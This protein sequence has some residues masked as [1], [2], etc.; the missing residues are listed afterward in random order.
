MTDAPRSRLARAPAPTAADHPGHIPNDP[1]PEKPAIVARLEEKHK[2]L[3]DVLGTFELDE[4]A[5]PAATE[6]KSDEDAAKVTRFATAARA[7][8][9]EAE[10]VRT[11]EKADFLKAGQAIDGLFNKGLKEPL[12]ALAEA[13]EKRLA[14]YLAAKAEA[15][16]ARRREEQERLRIAQ[17][18]AQQ[19][20]TEARAAAQAREA[21]AAAA[22]E[23]VRRAS[24]DAE[25]ETA[26]LAMQEAEAA[27]IVEQAA[28]DQAAT[29]TAKTERLVGQHE[30]VLAKG[31]GR[32]SA[33]KVGGAGEGSA[34]LEEK[35]VH[36]IVDAAAL[37]ASLG[38][39]AP[40]LP[41]YVLTEALARVAKEHE[42]RLSI[43]GVKFSKD[44]SVRTR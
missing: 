21:E 19:R 31:V 32:M 39:L 12:L 43:P 40:F 14:P 11:D 42:D 10:R 3:F 13:A 23:A 20:E 30:K 17:E 8:A 27:R 22:A 38:P 18:E 35:W 5:L 1:N 44:L 26:A 29:D 28:A 33:T 2:P 6:I 41:A 34:R 4:F 7:K 36:A 25:R 16:A 24:G 9:R 37:D 15:E